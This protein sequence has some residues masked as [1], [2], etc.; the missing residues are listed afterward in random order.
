MMHDFLRDN[1]EELTNRCRA[2]VA[3]RPERQASGAQLKNGVPIFLNQLIRTLEIEQTNSPLDSLKVSGQSG[4]GGKLSE[5]GISAST[6]G[7]ELMGLGFSVDQVVHDYGDLCQAITDLAVEVNTPF[8]VDE[9]RT[10]NRCLDNAIADSVTEFSYQHDVEISEKRLAE[11]NEKQGFFVHELRNL[12]HVSMLAFDAVK[13]G[14]LSLGGATGTVLWRSLEGLRVLIDA[15]VVE[16]RLLDEPNQELQ[17]FSLADFIRE[18]QEAAQLLAEAQKCTLAVVLID[19]GLAIKGT[20]D[21]LYSA[22]WNLVQNAFKYTRQGSEISLNAYAVGDYVKV[23]VGDHCGGLSSEVMDTMFESFTQGSDK[24]GLG[25]GL[26]TARGCIES[27]GGFITVKNIPGSGCV[28]TVS[29]PRYGLT[30]S[31]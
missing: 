30:Y 7:K 6:H 2:K 24:T 28:F 15:S 31:K 19:S 25:L 13:A 22:V 18:I 9:F 3:L 27:N 12:L 23:D 20:R 11:S 29:L 8:T 16:V 10:L 5:M 1:Y 14:G 26:S 21:T 4:G 17:I